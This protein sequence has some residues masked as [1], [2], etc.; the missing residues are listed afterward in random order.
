MIDLTIYGLHEINFFKGFLDNIKL[1]YNISITD[2]LNNFLETNDKKIS[3]IE[4]PADIMCG[5]NQSLINDY[6]NGM[7]PI[8]NNSDLSIIV[9]FE[10][11]DESEKILLKID[12]YTN[13]KN[14]IAM[15]GYFYNDYV[16]QNIK[17]LNTN[18]WPMVSCEVV[19]QIPEVQ[20]LLAQLTPYEPKDKLFDVLLGIGEKRIK[21]HRHFLYDMINNSSLKDK[22][23]MNFRGD[24]PYYG[25]SANSE[26]FD[27][28]F[29][30]DEEG[31][32][33]IPEQIEINHSSQNILYFGKQ[34]ML[35]IVVPLNIYNQT[36]YS[37]ITET[38]Y[39][40][41]FTL[42]SEKTVKPIIA[43]RLFIMFAG[44][45]YLKNLREIGRAHV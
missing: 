40:N 23:I 19:N 31:I 42:F 7:L 6:I 18:I 4:V 43:K 27:A 26:N 34:M 16:F 38:D 2:N 14:V 33:R 9:L 25:K 32:E 41:Y 24:V 28:D 30:L 1:K 13:T 3:I 39:L 21:P 11:H 20:T 17:V 44:K 35:A 12:Q 29:I 45:N 5:K 22:V 8:I 10:A 15:I 36:A 37:V